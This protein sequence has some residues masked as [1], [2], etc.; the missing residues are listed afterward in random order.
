MAFTVKASAIVSL[1]W[2]MSTAGFLYAQTGETSMHH[3][4]K[5]K[6]QIAAIPD[7][8]KKDS[9][10]V[11]KSLTPQTTCPIMGGAIN[12]KQY[13]DYKG[14][15]IYVCC[16]GCIGELKADPEKYIKKLEDMGQ[17]VETLTATP[18]TQAQKTGPKAKK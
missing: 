11:K 10:E 8:A 7:S 9:A 17:S 13:V 12:K 15:R 4:E 14:K 1:A 18:A 6:M 5:S 16:P 2:I 3:S